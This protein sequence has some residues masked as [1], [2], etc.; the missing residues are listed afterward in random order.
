MNNVK[1]SVIIP[2]YNVE[3]YLCQCLDSV[4]NQT[5]KDIEVIC[6]ND[7]STDNCP[8]ILDEYAKKDYAFPAGVCAGS[9]HG[10]CR[11]GS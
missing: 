7:G 6:V 4:I 2:V 3:K 5:I 9:V 10:A 11:F 1:V 8:K